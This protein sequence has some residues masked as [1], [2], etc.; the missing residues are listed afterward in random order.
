MVLGLGTGAV[1]AFMHAKLEWGEEVWV[2]LGR[3]RE[4]RGLRF[5]L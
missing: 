2:E 4:E 3:W 5:G 1:T